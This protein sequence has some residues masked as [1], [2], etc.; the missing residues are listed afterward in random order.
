MT[1]KE[2]KKALAGVSDDKKVLVEKLDINGDPIRGASPSDFV[3]AFPVF[4]TEELEKT[5]ALG[6]FQ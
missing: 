1:V 3:Q 6:I 5:F 2:L 4:K